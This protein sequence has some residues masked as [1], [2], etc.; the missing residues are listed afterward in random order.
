V[1]VGNNTQFL[2][3]VFFRGVP[4]ILGAALGFF[5]LRKFLLMILDYEIPIIFLA[6]L[7]VVI[8]GLFSEKHIK[9][10]IQASK[11]LDRINK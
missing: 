8:V 7:L 9:P 1:T 3:A 6:I 11:K 10:Y 2:K 5:A 4:L